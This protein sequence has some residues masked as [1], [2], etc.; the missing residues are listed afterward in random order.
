[1]GVLNL[2]ITWAVN[3]GSKFWR[4]RTPT[5]DWWLELN[6]KCT[7]YW[8]K[9]DLARPEFLVNGAPLNNCIDC[10][11]T[12]VVANIINKRKLEEDADWVYPERIPLKS[13]KKK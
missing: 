12:S 13:M 4:H 3:R 8:F 6:E 11:F 7:D 10:N 5:L 9:Y 2:G 1:M